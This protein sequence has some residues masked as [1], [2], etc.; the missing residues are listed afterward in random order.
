MRMIK[1][2]EWDFPSYLAK[3]WWWRE[4]PGA[5][6]CLM[7][8]LGSSDFRWWLRSNMLRT[9]WGHRYREE[10]C[11]CVCVCVSMDG[12]LLSWNVMV[13]WPKGIHEWISTVYVF[14]ETN[15]HVRTNI[16][17]CL[18][19]LKEGWHVKLWWKHP[20]PPCS[21]NTRGRMG[22]SPLVLPFRCPCSVLKASR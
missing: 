14:F 8:G 11:W 20:L 22:H 7:K 10:G 9:L 3:V 19:S 16:S 21:G 17:G 2:F 12:D 4:N 18:F 13:E 15:E 1:W 6:A 5:L